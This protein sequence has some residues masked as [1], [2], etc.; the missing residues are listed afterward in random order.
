MNNPVHSWLCASG[1]H[2]VF[3]SLKK[4]LPVKPNINLVGHGEKRL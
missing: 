4:M 2:S 3:L 1:D